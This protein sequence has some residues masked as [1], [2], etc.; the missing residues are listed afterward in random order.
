VKKVILA[1]A[2]A[3]VAVI[4]VVVEPTLAQQPLSPEL[5]WAAD[6]AGLN[7]TYRITPNITYLTA[8][9]TALK[10]DVYEP[11]NAGRPTPTLVYTHGGGW[12]GGSKE[13]SSLTF[14]PYLQMRWSVVNVEY[15]FASVALSPAAVEDTLC[16]LRWVI[17]NAKQYNFDTT[18]IVT[19][20][21]SSGGHLALMNGM[22]PASAGL[23]RQCPGP[24]ELKV[25]AIVNWYGP[26]DVANLLSGPNMR[27]WAV[28]WLGSQ[29]NREEIAKRVSPITYVRPGLPPILTIHGDADP[30]VPYEQSKRLHEALT[31]AGVPNQLLTIPGGRHDAPK[32]FTPNELRN[33]FSTIVQFLGS[34]GLGGP[35][36]TAQR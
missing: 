18:R 31:K 14:L 6:M 33:A 2:T 8:S 17:K 9:N 5:G 21:E 4:G 13:G 35:I 25:A 20:G 3:I 28:G 32:G 12:G 22:V 36:A 10:L 30:V 23:D 15:R 16:A 34:H 7:S 11:L 19:S 24:E 1:I 26:S 27:T 29:S